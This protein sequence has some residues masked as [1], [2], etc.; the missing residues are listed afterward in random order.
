M[1]NLYLRNKIFQHHH[2]HHHMWNDKFMLLGSK[3]WVMVGNRLFSLDVTVRQYMIALMHLHWELQFYYLLMWFC[4]QVMLEECCWI[5]NSCSDYI[6]IETIFWGWDRVWSTREYKCI[7]IW[8]SHPRHSSCKN[9][10]FSHWYISCVFYVVLIY[11]YSCTI[12]CSDCAVSYFLKISLK[13]FFLKITYILNVS[14]H[15]FPKIHFRT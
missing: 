2:Y 3:L 4:S 6:C 15:V 9:I 10:L 13:I 12:N 8:C 1:Q 7:I 5:R 14:T 11:K